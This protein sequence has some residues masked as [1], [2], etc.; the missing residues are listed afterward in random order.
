MHR[1]GKLRSPKNL[2]SKV[3][4]SKT[5]H[6]VTVDRCT[7]S[8]GDHTVIMRQLCD[9]MSPH[10]EPMAIPKQPQHLSLLR[11]VPRRPDPFFSG[12]YLDN[13]SLLF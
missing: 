6:V 11:T 5:D 12:S 3:R 9:Q 7:G 4:H 8:C 2:L 13:P 10:E 1:Q